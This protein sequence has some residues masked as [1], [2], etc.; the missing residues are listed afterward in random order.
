MQN[1]KRVLALALAM[2]LMLSVSIIGVGA[3]SYSDYPDVS[4]ITNTSSVAMV[5]E[6]GIFKGYEDGT[7]RADKVVTRAELAK[8]IC[9]M[10]NKGKD[11]GYIYA[12]DN[13]GLTDISSSWAKG[14][15]NYCSANGIINGYP[16]G[17]FRPNQT[18]TGVEAA[19]M[20]LTALGYDSSIEG[21][22]GTTWAAK[23]NSR[24]YSIGLYDDFEGAPIAGLTRDDTA[25]LAANLL[26]MNIVTGYDTSSKPTVS[27][28]TI[29]E[30]QYGAEAVTGEIIAN[31][32]ADLADGTSLAA[33][34]TTISP[35]DGSD[36]IT[37]N[38][39]TSLED[40]GT[41]VTIY[42]KTGTAKVYGSFVDSGLNS[43]IDVAG[44]I[45][46]FY[47]EIKSDVSAAQLSELSADGAIFANYESK[48]LA[49]LETA[50]IFTVSGTTIKFNAGYTGRFVD[51]DGDLTYDALF[52]D[53]PELAIYSV[54]S[55]TSVASLV[56]DASPA[57]TA[58][59]FSTSSSTDYVVDDSVSTGDYVLVRNI[60]GVYYIS[61]AE[62]GDATISKIVNGEPYDGSTKLTFAATKSY[63]TS[64]FTKPAIT[65]GSELT[66]IY[67]DYGNVITYKTKVDTSTYSPSYA[68]LYMVAKVQTGTTAFGTASYDYY[69]QLML[70][71]GSTD[72]FE[73]KLI[74]DTTATGYDAAVAALFAGTDSAGDAVNQLISYAVNT[75]GTVSL[76]SIKT[77]STTPL[78]A[79]AADTLNGAYDDGSISLTL[80]TVGKLYTSSLTKFFYADT[81]ATDFSLADD[82]SYVK[83]FTNSMDVA[84]NSS[85]YV[86]YNTS[87][88]I[89]SAIWFGSAPTTSSVSE[90]VYFASEN[91]IITKDSDGNYVYTY[92][93][94]GTDGVAQQ[95]NLD[96]ARDFTSGT[97]NTT[98]Y[99][100][101]KLV[102]SNG[103][104]SLSAVLGSDIDTGVEVVYYSD[105]VLVDSSDNAYVIGDD[106]VVYKFD[107]DEGT[108]VAGSLSSYDASESEGLVVDFIY[109]TYGNITAAIITGTYA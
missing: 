28:K 38:L 49:Q 109:D 80:D 7:F 54:N 37:V 56:T 34:K 62:S 84:D 59:T 100:A 22:T 78:Y 36:D 17:T 71:N 26:F 45:S 55:T 18:V 32:Y 46:D 107:T 12:D 108:L 75:D 19:K 105:D 14:Y 20:L 31:E 58:G 23:V 1:L 66:C 63:L 48:T 87:T 11:V 74:T 29:L 89:I 9:V 90:Y 2:A 73:I 51:F 47:T 24:A 91:A 81:S 86:V 16:D 83:G 70:D 6:L 3:T 33:G 68:F 41:S 61:K 35:L 88:K 13:S 57:A 52:I 79:K 97:G 10:L 85:V 53:V 101:Y 93:V 92:E 72:T 67:D 96:T 40:L 42:V 4:E 94:Y 98:L 65:V 103:E 106:V 15:I 50:G 25:L 77:A 27:E 76:S 69:A 21:Y 43:T 39:T 30:T 8:I 64:T 44:P 95:I 104:Q 5:T 82:S 99:T 102:E 60:D